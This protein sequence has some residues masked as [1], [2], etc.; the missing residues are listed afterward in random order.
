MALELAGVVREYGPV[1]A[2]DGANLSV[3]R[4]EV[5]GLIG[6]NGAGKSTMIKILS[7]LERADAG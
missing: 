1:R 6:Q 2:R 3:R 4:G 5:H 7:G